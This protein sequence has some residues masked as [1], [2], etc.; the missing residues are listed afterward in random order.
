[1]IIH[2]QHL[3]SVYPCVERALTFLYSWSN[4]GP[5]LT[6]AFSFEN[7]YFSMH[8][9]LPSTLKR[10]KRH[11]KRRFSKT[12]AFSNET[13]SVDGENEDFWKRWFDLHIIYILQ[14][15][16]SIKNL[17]HGRA[18]MIWKRLCGRKTFA[19][20]SVKW[21]RRFLKTGHGLSPPV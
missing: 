19:T 10:W 1:M 11:W 21:K 20:F 18:K 13:H 2:S 8:F 15:A 5:V 16:P 7:T 3:L 6:N 12:H 17:S 4:W 14:N 9:R